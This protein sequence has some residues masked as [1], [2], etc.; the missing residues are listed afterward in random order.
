MKVRYGV[1]I[2]LFLSGA[3]VAAFWV[4]GSVVVRD[5]ERQLVSAQVTTG[6]GRTQPLYLFPGR[7][8]YTVPRLEG[9]VEFH[10]RTG[11]VRRVGYV[12]FNSHEWRKITGSDCRLT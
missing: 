11:A 1:G 4:A 12:T 6:D 8:F 5:P 2:A 9:D 7:L 3:V 10:C